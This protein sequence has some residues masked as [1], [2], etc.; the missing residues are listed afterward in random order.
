MPNLDA[1]NIAYQMTK[2]LADALAVGPILIGAAHAGAY[3]DALG[4]RARRHQ[5][6]GARGGGGA[7]SR[8]G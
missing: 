4:H 7:G 8:A 6:D 1:A 2:V 3:P 5:H